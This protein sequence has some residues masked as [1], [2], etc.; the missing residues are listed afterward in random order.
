M[1]KKE[2]MSNYDIQ[3][4]DARRLFLRHDQER[5]IKRYGLSAD[6]M[7]LYL[8]YLHTPC[9]ISRKS[10]SV[11]VRSRG[12][13]W[14]ECRGFDTVMTI[15]DLLCHA[16]GDTAPALSGEWCTVGHF[17]IVTSPSAAKFTKKYEEAFQNHTK[18]LELACKSLGGVLQE[19]MAGADITCLIHVTPYFPVLLQFW[20]GDDEFLPKLSLLW[21]CNSMEFL[22]FETT[23]YLQGDIL[24][25]LGREMQAKQDGTVF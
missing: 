13:A 24:E 4:E 11:E 22:H 14:E 21:D 16:K 5:I 6:E 3:A 15:Y 23:F 18:E 10:G 9:R 2:K 12:E 8:E 20:D 1:Q 17:T 25:R 19:K 7:W